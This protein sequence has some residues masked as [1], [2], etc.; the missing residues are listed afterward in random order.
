MHLDDLQHAKL[1]VVTGKGGVGKTTVAA[2][3]ALAAA[4]AGRRTMVCEV[5][6]QDR[7]ARMFGAGG[8]RR[9]AEVALGDDL[10]GMSIDPIGALGEWLGRLLPGQAAGLLARSGTFGAFVSAAPGS[11]ELVSVTKAWELSSAKR[12]SKGREP[13]DVVVLDAPASG[14]GLGMLRAPRTYA[15]IA[16]VGPIATQ[17]RHVAEALVD[18]AHTAYVAVTIPTELAVTETLELEDRL[19]AM[20]GRELDG[21]VCNGVLPRRFDTA[22]CTRV[23]EVGGRAARAVRA[24]TG[25]GRAQHAQIERLRRHARAPVGTL[26]FRFAQTLGPDDVEALAARLR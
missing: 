13:Y 17:A 5:G 26:P 24:A 21:I 16:R 2:A 14:H 12:W 25:R 7:M 10:W 1:V 20:L 19:D 22:S 11:A 15:D 18:P 9:G 4:R 6:A 8:A 23:T 3:L